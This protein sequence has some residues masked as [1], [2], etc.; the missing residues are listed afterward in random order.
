MAW[1]DRDLRGIFQAA[2]LAAAALVALA[3]GAVAKEQILKCELKRHGAY[4]GTPTQ[5]VIAYQKGEGRMVVYDSM[6][7]YFKRDPVL[8]TVGRDT[9]KTL[10]IRW[11]LSN[12]KADSGYIYDVRYSLSWDKPSGRAKISGRLSVSDDSYTGTGTCA[13]KK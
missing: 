1:G 3:G 9:D 10:V 13:F 6:M 4:Q 2:A 7:A 8:G 5:V 12:V 11:K